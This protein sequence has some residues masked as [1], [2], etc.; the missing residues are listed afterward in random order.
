MEKCIE[1]IGTLSKILGRVHGPSAQV[2]PNIFPS[3]PPTQSISTYS[4]LHE[5][6]HCS[7]YLQ[8]K[9]SPFK[10]AFM[11][12]SYFMSRKILVKK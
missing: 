12:P 1:V 11:L 4:S 9:L 2:G 8:K 5:I 10:N 6:A 3:G 7:T